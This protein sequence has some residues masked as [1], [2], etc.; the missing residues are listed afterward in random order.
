MF[1]SGSKAPGSK[2][3]KASSRSEASQP[4]HGGDAHDEGMEEDV[5]KE[6]DEAQKLAGELSQQSAD[7]R[8]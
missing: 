1:Y 8:S 7:Q 4:A 5:Q 3:S 2:G 6:K